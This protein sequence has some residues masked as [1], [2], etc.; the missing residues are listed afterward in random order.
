VLPYLNYIKIID[1]STADQYEAK[2]KS[3]VAL[4]EE[5][6]NV[7]LRF[8]LYYLL[9]DLD[10][11][12][13]RLQALE[14]ETHLSEQISYCL[15]LL[16][17]F[18]VMAVALDGCPSDHLV[19]HQHVDLQI[20]TFVVPEFE[21]LHIVL[22]K[23]VVT[24]VFLWTPVVVWIFLT[25]AI[26]GIIGGQLLTVDVSTE[27]LALLLLLVGLLLD[28]LV[29]GAVGAGGPSVGCL[30]LSGSLAYDGGFICLIADEEAAGGVVGDVGVLEAGEIICGI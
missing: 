30:F 2:A 26:F 15:V 20:F 27:T 22:H 13:W 3:L 28:V 29:G 12:R 10:L 14:L 18:L 8:S 1:C 24:S 23:L 11:R 19:A 5:A 7:L 4:F 6:R 21:P 17:H 25:I 9:L 16:H